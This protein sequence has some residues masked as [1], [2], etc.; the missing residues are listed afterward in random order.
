MQAREF[1]DRHMLASAAEIMAKMAKMKLKGRMNWS[2]RS[3][4]WTFPDWSELRIDK[5]GKVWC[6]R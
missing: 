4:T 5:N 6:Y 1:A 3:I 2:A